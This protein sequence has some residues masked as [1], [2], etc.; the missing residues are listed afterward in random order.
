M[1]DGRMSVADA[2]ERTTLN[3]ARYA[4]RQITWIRHQFAD[5]TWIEV[6]AARPPG[7][8]GEKIETWICANWNRIAAW[9]SR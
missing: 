5:V 4:K 3:T 7:S 8:A 6:G 2:I 9:E 1:L